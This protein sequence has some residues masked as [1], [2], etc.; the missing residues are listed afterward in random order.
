MILILIT[1]ISHGEALSV[2]SKYN[3][4]IHLRTLEGLVYKWH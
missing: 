4:F 1:K 2:I 3:N